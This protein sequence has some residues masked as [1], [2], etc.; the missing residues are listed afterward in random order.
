ML[1]GTV[2]APAATVGYEYDDTGRLK[3]VTYDNGTVVNYSLDASGNR[4]SYSAVQGPTC[5]FGALNAE[6]SDEFTVYVSLQRTA[7]C[8]QSVTVTVAIQRISGTGNYSIGTLY[9]GPIISPG[10]QYK[11]QAIWPIYGSVSPGSPLHLKVTWRISSGNGVI[12]PSE[13]YATIYN[14]DCY[15]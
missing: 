1:G 10:D 7:P 5:T 11:Q 14:S 15:C 6:G 2:V 8:S 4:I 9:G 12:S 13:S 3:R